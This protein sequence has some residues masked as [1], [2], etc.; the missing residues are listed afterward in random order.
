MGTHWQKTI[1][2]DD[3]IKKLS[4][5]MAEHGRNIVVTI[6]GSRLFLIPYEG[7]ERDEGFKFNLDDFG[8]KSRNG[9]KS[10]EIDPS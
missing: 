1:M 7:D 2:I 5:I 10:L 3:F 6:K 4:K 9:V 8:D